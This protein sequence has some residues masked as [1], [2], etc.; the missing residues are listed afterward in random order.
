MRG[1]ILTPI[2]L[3]S[4]LAVAATGSSAQTYPQRINDTGMTTCYAGAGDID[5]TPTACSNSNWPGQDG[6]RGRDAAGPSL[7]KVGAGAAGFDFSKL[8]AAGA[9]LPAAAAPGPGPNDWACTRD[10]VTG[11]TWRIDVATD[12]SWSVAALQAQQLNAGGGNC[13]FADWRVPTTNEL[14]GLVHFGAPSPAI[15]SNYFPN[16]AAVFYWSSDVDVAAPTQRARIVNLSAG[17]IHVIDR[18]APASL[19]L[20]RGGAH[21][22][23]AIDNGNGTVT[24]PRTGLMWDR[25]A[26]GQ[27]LSDGCA[28]EPDYRTW[29]QALQDAAANNGHFWRGYSDWRLPN[30]KELASLIDVS[31]RRPAIDDALFANAGSSAYWSST[32]DLSVWRMAWAVF[33]GEGNLFAKDKATRAAVRLVRTASAASQGGARDELFADGFDLLELPATTPVDEVPTIAITTDGGAPINHD[34]YVSGSITISAAGQLPAYSGTLQIKG[35]G[36]STWGMPK[37]PYR[38]KLDSKAGLLGMH[39]DKNWALLANYADKSMLRNRIGQTLGRELQ[40]GWSPDSRFA[41]L[42]LNGQYQGLYE[43]IET[44]RV[45][46]DRVDI[47]EMEPGDVALPE[48]SGGYLFEIDQRRDCAANVFFTTAQNVPICID[49]PDEDEIVPQQLA[50]LSGYVQGAEDALYAADFADPQ[51]GYR[52]WLD[53][54]SFVD[55]YLVNEL[56]ANVDAATYSSIWNFKDR[57]GLMRRG[58]LWD[59]DLGTGNANYRT[60]AD[61]RGFWVHDGIWYERLFQDPTFAAQVRARWDATRASVFDTLPE[62]ID[63]QAASIAGAMPANTARWPIMTSYVWPNVVVTGS[64]EGELAYNKD[65]LL[66]RIAWLDAN[67]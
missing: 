40:M 1:S 42:T 4:L 6:A 56:V 55:W 14:L 47:T 30:A 11:L 45:S 37:K 8:S 60:C 21:F 20:V 35:R 61:P 3:G 22:A 57:N 16:L 46:A 26:L 53:P 13:G 28:G 63:S 48:V 34:T 64:W 2:L 33:F 15:D 52:A 50:Y 27:T 39:E 9:I 59:F 25:C 36:N 18:Q 32:T 62:L 29:Q 19:M 5:A 43:L 12:V 66:Q 54:A 10:N 24:D 23:R 67:L 7:P 38:I 17:F 51:T 65:W 49:T 58:P 44:I 31:R 41:K